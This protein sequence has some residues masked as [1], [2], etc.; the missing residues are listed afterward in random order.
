LKTGL[1]G[2]KPIRSIGWGAA[3]KSLL[4]NFRSLIEAA[5]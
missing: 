5:T 1:V 4:R 3:K 2:E